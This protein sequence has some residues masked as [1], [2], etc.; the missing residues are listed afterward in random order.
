MA[1]S[2]RDVTRLHAVMRGY[3][4]MDS[5]AAKRPVDD[6]LGA[7]DEGIE[8]VRV[9]IPS[10]FFF[11]D[12]DPEIT[13][14]VRSVAS[15]LASLGADVFEFSLPG[16]DEATEICSLIIRADA[17][18]LHRE[19]LDEYPDLFGEEV[20]DRLR[21]GEVITGWE[22]ARL[23][24]RMYEW[25][26]D[27]RTHFETEV[28]LILT[29]T[30]CIAAPLIDGAEMIATTAQLTRLTYPWSLAHL[31]AISIPCGF[32]SDGLPVGAQLGADLYQETSLL[33][34]AAA[35]QAV[36]D[37]HRCR[38]ARAGGTLLGPENLSETA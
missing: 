29:P 8:S 22:F 24:E 28:D 31:P 19:R 33:R 11:E 20:R 12:V 25:R 18:G 7:P 27:V 21:L 9:G 10:E 17:L 34:A 4:L 6:P 32:T 14:L 26:R 2:V 38:P 36:T 37:W 23:V 3:D 16:A 5:R 30:A 15:E 35:Y 13:Q 1:R